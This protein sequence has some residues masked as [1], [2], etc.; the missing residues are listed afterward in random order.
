M[1]S[2]PLTEGSAEQLTLLFRGEFQVSHENGTFAVRT[3][4]YQTVEQ[5]VAEKLALPA[6]AKF[7]RPRNPNGGTATTTGGH[8]A[9]A[10]WRSR[11][12]R[13]TPA[14]LVEAVMRQYRDDHAGQSPD[15]RL[16]PR[17][18]FGTDRAAG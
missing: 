9:A 12:A 14:S 18:A 10:H 4:G 17:I 16:N 15:P 2:H 11:A 3:A 1:A 5:F 6:Y 7:L 13:S 8:Q